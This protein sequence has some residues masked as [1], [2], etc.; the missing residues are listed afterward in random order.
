MMEGS[1]LLRFPRAGKSLLTS[2]LQHGPEGGHEVQPGN[3]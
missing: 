1:E 2:M 3:E